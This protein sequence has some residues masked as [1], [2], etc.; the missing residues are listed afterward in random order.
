MR[1]LVLLLG[2]AGALTA[3]ASATAA[4]SPPRQ[5]P[6]CGVVIF[7]PA[8]TTGSSQAQMEKAAAYE[9]VCVGR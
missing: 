1:R 8:A 9:R 6:G 7:T 2:V 5:P 4:A 3:G